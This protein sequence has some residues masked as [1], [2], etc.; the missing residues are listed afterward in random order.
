MIAVRGWSKAGWQC[1]YA[2]VRSLLLHY[3]SIAEWQVTT[4]FY[5]ILCSSDLHNGVAE[6]GVLYK[7]HV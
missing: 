3:T 4:P 6:C 7:L 2:D 5:W 1:F